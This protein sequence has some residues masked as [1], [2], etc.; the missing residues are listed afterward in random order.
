MIVTVA[1]PNILLIVST[2]YQ[3]VLCKEQPLGLKNED[4]DNVDV[5]K[6]WVPLEA[7]CIKKVI[8][9]VKSLPLQKRV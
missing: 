8:P 5:P 6:T 1:H 7:G 3:T 4:E 9:K 2:K